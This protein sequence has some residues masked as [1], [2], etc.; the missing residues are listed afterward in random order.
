MKRRLMLLF[1]IVWVILWASFNIRELF[2]KGNIHDYKVLLSKNIDDKRSY[3]TGDRFYEFLKF[4][5]TV[6]PDSAEYRWVKTC[7]DELDRRRSTYYLYP[8]LESEDARFV[9]V[10]D[11]AYMPDQAY[12]VFAVLDNAR[13]ILKMKE[14]RTNWK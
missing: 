6:L 12:E 1:L 8:H 2:M 5:N 13:Y 4:C 11:D 7:K 9:L 14:R 10:Y 3:V